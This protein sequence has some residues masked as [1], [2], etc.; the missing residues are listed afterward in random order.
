MLSNSSYYNP[1]WECV[2]VCV[3]VSLL[4][5]H[6]FVG[7]DCISKCLLKFKCMKRN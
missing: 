1:L 5:M 7:H 4:H 6:V 3:L 2:C